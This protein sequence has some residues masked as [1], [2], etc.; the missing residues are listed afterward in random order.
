[1]IGMQRRD[2]GGDADGLDWFS[3]PLKQTRVLT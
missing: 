2:A 1:M 3:N